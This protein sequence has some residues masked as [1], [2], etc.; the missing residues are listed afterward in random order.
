MT[1]ALLARHADGPA[2][3]YYNFPTPALVPGLRKFDW[4]IGHEIETYYR[5]QR[6]RAV[7]AGNGS[8]G[9]K[10]PSAA[11][12]R[13]A[14]VASPLVRG[15]V[16]LRTLRRATERDLSVERH[17]SVPSY[18]LA[19]LYQRTAPDA[20]HVRHDARFYRWRFA[21]PRWSTTTYVAHRC[22]TPEAAC[23]ACTETRGGFTTTG[24]LDVLPRNRP[25]RRDAYRALLRAVVADAGDS[26]VLRVGGGDIPSTV[27]ASFGFWSTRSFPLSA[28]SNQTRMAVRPVGDARTGSLKLGGMDATDVRQWSLPLGDQDVA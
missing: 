18:L 5:I 16:H 24:L 2:A 20:I 9:R 7:L 1:E 6:P 4:R 3:L 14:R 23:V 12:A 15:Y 27:L 25:D 10:L 11:S 28:I 21:N 13:L 19:E 17:G 22:G 26:D 8:T